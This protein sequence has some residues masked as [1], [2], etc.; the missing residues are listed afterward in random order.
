M[1]HNDLNLFENE[2]IFKQSIESFN[3][4]DTDESS[5]PS[6]FIFNQLNLSNNLISIQIMINLNV[7]IFK[8][9]FSLLKKL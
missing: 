3:Y 7:L 2:M 5:F 1:T 9:K 4:K 6:N 8:I